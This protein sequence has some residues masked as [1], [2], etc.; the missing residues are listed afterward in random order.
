MVQ[1]GREFQRGSPSHEERRFREEPGTEAEGKTR[2]WGRE[3]AQT[4]DDE[5]DR[6]RG[7]VAVTGKNLAADGGGLA[8]QAQALFDGGQNSRAARMD[9]PGADRIET[10]AVL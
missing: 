8:G 2:Q 10:V 6:R 1:C 5:Q 4:V 9:G 7:H 3:F